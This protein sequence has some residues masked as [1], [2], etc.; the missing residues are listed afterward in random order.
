MSLAT[1]GTATSGPASG[2]PSRWQLARA[3][4][5]AG[6]V[7]VAIAARAAQAD[8]DKTSAVTGTS[9]EQGSKITGPFDMA[10]DKI[11]GTEQFRFDRK[12]R[13]F[14]RGLQLHLNQFGGLESLWINDGPSNDGL[15]NWG[16]HR[17]TSH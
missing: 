9:Y 4:R 15:R 10:L 7:R 2:R 3:A 13:E 11:T 5:A 1:A 8:R 17:T 12:K 14:L 16:S 6:S